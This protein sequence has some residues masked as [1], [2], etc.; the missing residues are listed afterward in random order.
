MY[1]LEEEDEEDEEEEEHFDEGIFE[2]K[3]DLGTG[4]QQDELLLDLS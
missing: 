3:P 4:K 1:K 2:P